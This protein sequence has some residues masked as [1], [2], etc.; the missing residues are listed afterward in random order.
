MATTQADI[1]A[2]RTAINSGVRKVKFADRETEY[3]DLAE[4]RTILV[5]MER[6]VAGTKRTAYTSKGYNR[7][8]QS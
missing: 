7:G 5:S 4:M 2:L 8:Y 1:D 6:E 3:R